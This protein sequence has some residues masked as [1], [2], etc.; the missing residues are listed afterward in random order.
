MQ[1]LD[2]VHERFNRERRMGPAARLGAT[3][4]ACVL[5]GPGKGVVVDGP[6]TESKEQLLAFTSSTAPIA[7]PRSRRRATCARPIL[8]RCTK[9][10]RSSSIVRACH[11]R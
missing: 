8:P 11:F 2:K 9:S 4:G 7:M 6:F 1:G 5:R 10:G 3:N